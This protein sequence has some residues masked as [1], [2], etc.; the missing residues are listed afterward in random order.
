MDTPYHISVGFTDMERSDAA[1]IADHD[2]KDQAIG[3]DSRHDSLKFKSVTE[4]RNSQ[5]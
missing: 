2:R 1:H 5:I 4:L 3:Y